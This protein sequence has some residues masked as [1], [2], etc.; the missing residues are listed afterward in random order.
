MSPL[1][2]L[3]EWGRR[4][5]DVSATPTLSDRLGADAF[6][7]DLIQTVCAVS[8]K[9]TKV[10]EMSESGAAE[11]GNRRRRDAFLQQANLGQASR[12][13]IP[14]Q[15]CYK[16]RAKGLTISGLRNAIAGIERARL[17]ILVRIGVGFRFGH[18]ALNHQRTS[19]PRSAISD[20]GM[21]RPLPP[22][23]GIVRKDYS[24]A[25]GEAAHEHHTPGL[26]LN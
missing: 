12:L 1:I 18:R 4:G 6:A 15:R 13:P 10:M 25:H 16:P 19:S 3:R 17:A 21:D 26:N 11:G 23:A 2:R 22:A 8:I 7:A 24:G 5:G 20:N 14:V 9:G